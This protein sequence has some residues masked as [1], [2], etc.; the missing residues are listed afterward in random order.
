MIDLRGDVVTVPKPAV[1]Q[2]MSQVA[3]GDAGLDISVPAAGGARTLKVL[4]TGLASDAHTWNLVFLQKYVE[5]R[6]HEVLN[7][8]SC[9]PDDMLAA[10]CVR[11]APDLL[12]VSSVNGH[13]LSDGLRAIAVLRARPELARLP[14]VIGGKL[15]TAGKLSAPERERL[16]TAGFD[17]IFDDTS[18]PAFKA[19]LTSGESA[20]DDIRRLHCLA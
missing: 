15:S 6:G 3:P 4:I 17:A 1:R 7:L 12:V 16:T 19:M 14:I 20:R 18:M 9:V 13:G 8:G 2:A 5:E 10:A 11:Y